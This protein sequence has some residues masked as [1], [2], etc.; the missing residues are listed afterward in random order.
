MRWRAIRRASLLFVVVLAW[1]NIASPLDRP[2]TLDVLFSLED[3]HS[4]AISPDGRMAA[5]VR[6][7]SRL[8]RAERYLG[9]R[10]A[11]HQREDVWIV[12]LQN[13]AHL[14]PLTHGSLEGSSYWGPM[15]S[16]D[17]RWLLLLS[18]RGFAN[19]HL[20]LI[21]TRSGQMRRISR[22][23]INTGVDVIG[24]QTVGAPT[25]QGW[26]AARPMAWLDARRVL[27]AELA[28]TDVSRELRGSTRRIVQMARDWALTE[29]GRE[30]SYNRLDS[31]SNLSAASTGR[32]VTASIKGGGLRQLAEGSFRKVVVSPDGRL[33]AAITEGEPIRLD[34]MS[35]VRWPRSRLSGPFHTSFEVIRLDGPNSPIERFPIISDPGFDFLPYGKNGPPS[36]KL[37]ESDFGTEWSLVETYAG[38]MWIP[39]QHQVVLLAK[40]DASATNSDT[41]YVVDADTGRVQPNLHSGLLVYALDVVGNTLFAL[42]TVSH[43]SSYANGHWYAVN[44]TTLTGGALGDCGKGEIIH[45]AAAIGAIADLKSGAM[46]ILRPDASVDRIVVEELAGAQIRWPVVASATIGPAIIQEK[47]GGFDRLAWI[48]ES[49]ELREIANVQTRN[50]NVLTETDSASRYF[51]IDPQ[52]GALAIVQ[53]AESGTTLDAHTTA[54]GWKHLLSLNGVLH[55]IY[56]PQFMDLHYRTGDG[57]DRSARLYLPPNYHTGIKLPVI[58]WVYIQ[59]AFDQPVSNN[60]AFFENMSVALGYGFGVLVPTINPDACSFSKPR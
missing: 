14:R 22:R 8:G 25:E 9:G 50:A 21:D 47:S 33:A 31:P 38:P 18:D 29:Q 48:G 28:A 11:P 54:G 20:E 51:A 60:S 7:R 42:A 55:G 10:L 24:P 23:G 46:C 45:L 26:S 30:A 3:I 52:H 34:G 17:G 56:V 53:R 58:T 12:D 4:V 19:V 41:I 1:A 16:P 40:A 5:V 6:S 27:F 39:G 2:L 36:H 15:W 43:E 37:L 32:L 59:Q 49:I 13:P 44:G 57:S 35:P